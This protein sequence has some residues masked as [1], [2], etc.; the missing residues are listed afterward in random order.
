M[1]GPDCSVPRYPLVNRAVWSIGRT[2]TA[3]DRTTCS[4]ST[5]EVTGA[6]KN[7]EDAKVGTAKA[8]WVPALHHH[9]SFGPRGFHEVPDP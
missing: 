4:T 6:R 3:T 5:L 2:N 8:L 9:G 7:D 1:G